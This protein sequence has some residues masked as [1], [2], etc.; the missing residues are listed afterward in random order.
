[1]R[2]FWRYG[3]WQPHEPPK[4]Q[5]GNPRPHRPF[6]VRV[7]GCGEDA[8]ASSPLRM[9]EFADKGLAGARVDAIAE[10]S[11]SNKRMI[12]YYFNSKEE[13]YIA[14]LE[15]A[16][17]PT[18]APARARPRA[19]QSRS[20]RGHPQAG[21]VQVRLLRRAP[22]P[23]QAAQRREHAD[24]EYLKQSKR[25]RDMH[26]SLVK[27]SARILKPRRQERDDPARDQSACTCTS[28]SRA[29]AISTSPTRPRCRPRSATTWQRLPSVQAAPP[30]RRRR[31]HGLYLQAPRAYRRIR[32]RDPGLPR[33][34]GDAA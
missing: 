9:A 16:Y 12:Y 23:D 34:T 11:G 20:G 2:E 21:R 7:R 14:V 32:H 3:S 8:S 26:A 17:M 1:M 6:P 25:L 19:R 4:S 15:R 33:R 22:D 10:D 28:R 5:S 27:R 24:A 31:D 30:A 29:S 18:C 13:L